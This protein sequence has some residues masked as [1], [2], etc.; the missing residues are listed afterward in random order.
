MRS[1][2]VRSTLSLALLLPCAVFAQETPADAATS[3]A[4]A[5]DVT[6]DAAIATEAQAEVSVDAAAA[7]EPAMEAMP[8]AMPEA[9]AANVA[10]AVT[11]GLISAPPA[12]KGQVV[13]Y[14]PSKMMGA[15]IGFKVREGET[16]LG[17]L[18][19]GKYFVAAVEP[20]VHEY[21]VHGETKDAMTLEIEAG[22]TYYVQ[23]TLGMGIVAGRPNLSPSDEATFM[24]MSKKLKLAK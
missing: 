10:V 14:R 20:G 21:K 18:R 19:N 7:A 12:G 11:N 6:T 15:A 23:G 16:E 2:L 3:G 13:F 9:V 5:A 4:V 8:E 24:G 22:E 17:K 1:L